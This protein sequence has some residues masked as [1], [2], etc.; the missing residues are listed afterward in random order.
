MMG[1]LSTE[2][3][4][5]LHIEQNWLMGA[6]ALFGITFLAVWYFRGT[7][8]VSASRMLIWAIIAYL[9]LSHSIDVIG[10]YHSDI[11]SVLGIGKSATAPDVLAGIR[12]RLLNMGAI[13]VL[14]IVSIGVGFETAK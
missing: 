14:G 11:P 7:F 2:T 10:A 5:I 4:E 13:I 12:A 1:Q 6:S 3:A 9:A 8:S